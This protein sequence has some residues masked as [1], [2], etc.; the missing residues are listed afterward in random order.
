[1]RELLVEGQAELADRLARLAHPSMG[2]NVGRLAH[3]VCGLAG[4]LG[5]PLVAGHAARAAEAARAGHTDVD[6]L[7]SLMEAGGPSLAAL[8]AWAP[9]SGDSGAAGGWRFGNRRHG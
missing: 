6:A 8:Q 1:M 7:A 4:S 5:L 9:P 3:Q 2:E